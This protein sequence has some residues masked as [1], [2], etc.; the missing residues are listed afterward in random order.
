MEMKF[1]GVRELRQDALLSPP[2]I[3]SLRKEKYGHL[4]V[5]GEVSLGG[6]LEFQQ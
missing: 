2:N 6:N 3:Y 4:T 5:K 1:I